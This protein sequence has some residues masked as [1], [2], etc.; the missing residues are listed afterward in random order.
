MRNLKF[1]FILRMAEQFN[2]QSHVS[3]LIVERF[4]HPWAGLVIYELL[5]L[6]W[7]FLCVFF[8]YE[9]NELSI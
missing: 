5:T 3:R 8:F 4:Y 6:E 2:D 7:R 9:V 1:E